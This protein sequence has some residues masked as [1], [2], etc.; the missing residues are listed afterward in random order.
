MSRL[1][2]AKVPEHVA[3]IMDGNGRWA[4]GQG[5]ARVY[6]HQSGAQRVRDVVEAAGKAGVKVLTLYAFSEENW[7]RPVDEVNALFSLLVSYLKQEID[8]LHENKVRLRS[9]GFT[10][11]LPD[12]CQ[13]WLK[14][15]EAKTRDNDGLQ[16]VLAL[17][18]SGRSDLVR[19]MQKIAAAVQ[20]G[21]LQP[22]AIGEQVISENLSTQG[23]PEPDLLIRTSGE[24]RL[25]NFLL[26]E[27]AYTEFYFTKVH[28]PEFSREHLTEAL[29][30][31]A[32]RDRRFGAVRMDKPVC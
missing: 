17:S 11:K 15:V 21:R 13:E 26:W 8:Q 16:L 29:R 9:I 3:I 23:L 24:Q 20:E 31:Y 22:D 10:D 12:D 28:W 6:G 27:M 14:L 2:Q 5:K 4:Q 1:S 18:Y 19:A 25:S 30:E 32:D 7:R